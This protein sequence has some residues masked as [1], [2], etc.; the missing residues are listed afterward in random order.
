MNTSSSS[1]PSASSKISHMSKPRNRSAAPGARCADPADSRKAVAAPLAIVVAAVL[2]ACS[3]GPVTGPPATDSPAA[4]PTPTPVPAP[5]SAATRP[6]ARWVPAP[7]SDLPGW[8]QDAVH[9]AWPALLRSCARPAAGWEA[10]CAAARTQPPQP[11]QDAA[12]TRAW[13]QQQLQP[14]R[15]ESLEGQAAGLLTGYFE[16]LLD[17]RRRPLPPYTVPLHAPPADLAAR[18]PWW[19]RAELASV[20]AARAALAGRELAYVAD[21]LEALSIQIQGSGRVRLL[22]EPGPDGQPRVVRLAF[23]GHNDQPYRSVGR[24]LIDQGELGAD[25]ASWPA[26]RAWARLHPER[27]DEMLSANPRVVFFREEPLPNPALGPNGAQGVPLTPGRS[28][29]VDRNA[30]PYGT[31]VWL[32]STEP[33]PWASTAQATLPRALQRLVVAQDTGSAII[34]AVRADYF[35]GWGE[36]AEAQAG[37]TKQPLRLWALWPRGSAPGR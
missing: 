28:V 5:G 20:P 17:A 33:Q 19:S 12:A 16:P 14:Y 21:P 13:L 26:I 32:V 23:A 15:I 3:H 35:W 18:R 25:Q 1:A 9:E 7:W 36:D 29:A 34:G 4:R 6:V 27:I 2:A 22:D 10:T 37:R 24:W 8:S 31:P 11:P 30:I